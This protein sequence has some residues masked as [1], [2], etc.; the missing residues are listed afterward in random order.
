MAHLAQVER[1]RARAEDVTT[2]WFVRHHDGDRY[3]PTLRRW[4]A[5]ESVPRPSPH[6]REVGNI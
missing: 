2:S 1:K 4:N 6:L 3:D 5:S